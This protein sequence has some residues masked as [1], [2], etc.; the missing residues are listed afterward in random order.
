MVKKTPV[1]LKTELI[2]SLVSPAI[3][4]GIATACL[5]MIGGLL[6]ALVGIRASGE[7]TALRYTEPLGC[8]YY[9]AG[10]CLDS[11]TR[12][13]AQQMGYTNW[14]QG[15]CKVI[16]YCSS[17]AQ[18][19]TVEIAGGYDKCKEGTFK[20]GDGCCPN[21][22]ECCGDS[23]CCETPETQCKESFGVSFCAAVQ[24]ADG[25]TKCSGDVV[26]IHR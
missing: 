5:G 16:S 8:G 22:T 19:Y 9:Q 3:V 12:R 4:L 15:S 10:P 11:L 18:P 21:G 20:C 1:Q 6:F 26:G 7:F 13:E 25:E 17:S 14:Q 24:C 2:V 23:A